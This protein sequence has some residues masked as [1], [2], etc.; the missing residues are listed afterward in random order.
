MAAARAL[1][2]E[3]EAA[4]VQLYK[5]G[6]LTGDIADGYGVH[7]DTIRNIIKRDPDV[8]LRPQG[9]VEGIKRNREHRPV[10]A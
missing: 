4:V 6:E 2:K 7:P 1:T 8:K 3:Q 10:R 5:Q 9:G